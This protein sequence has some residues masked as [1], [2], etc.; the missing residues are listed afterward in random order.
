MPEGKLYIVATPIGN[1]EDI[2]LRAL[3]T[4]REVGV[5]VS[6][7]TRRARILLE[8]YGINKVPLSY[9]EHNKKIMAEKILHFLKEGR[10]VALIS[11]AGTP[12][13]SDPGAELVRESR[14]AGIQVIPV[15][16]PSSI[17]T[18]LSISGIELNFFTFH[19][20][21]PHKENARNRVIEETL[22]DG[23]IHVFFEAPHR[24]IRTLAAVKNIS[25]GSNVFL[26]KELTKIHEGVLSGT[27]GQL[28]DTVK[29]FDNIK[30]EWIIVITGGGE[31]KTKN[32]GIAK[33]IERFLKA[34]FT[35]HEIFDI[36][37][38]MK[39]IPKKIVYTELLKY[40]NGG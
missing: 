8:K 35:T 38:F 14:N 29:N 26:F 39:S 6:E 24:L 32:T 19:G 9:H 12:G 33:I 28:L 34:G 13:I 5:I 10:D 31:K 40:R 17:I 1:L 21:L 37:D 22:C 36:M 20:F 27:A 23:G 25:G 7:D 2:T 3:R 15:P 30:G 16:G 4:M 18:A 11:D